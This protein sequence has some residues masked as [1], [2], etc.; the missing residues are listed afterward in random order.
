MEL[1][2]HDLIRVKGMPSFLDN[3]ACEEWVTEAMHE[4]PFVVVRRA[5][6]ENEMI[7]VGIRGKSRSHRY[8]AF[9][10]M[11]ELEEVI[12]PEKLANEKRWLE[13][14]RLQ[15]IKVLQVLHEVDEILSN[16]DIVWGP[17][18][19]AGFELA[20]GIPTLTTK[21]DLDLI[22]R[23]QPQLLLVEKAR[24][25]Y[26]ELTNIETRVDVQLETPIGAIALAEYC[27]EP[28]QILTRTKKGPKLTK[29]SLLKE[30]VKL[31][32]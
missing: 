9:L 7:P 23:T 27:L 20:S 30:T 21:S 16:H 4:A 28:E 29:F 11:D 18:G 2:T 6:I 26:Q 10:H 19:S 22:I 17:G 3:E 1:R 15:E 14:P 32:G 31:N 13:N 25:I 24:Q 5:P 8:A 12:S